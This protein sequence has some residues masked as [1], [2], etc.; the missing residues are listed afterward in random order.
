MALSAGRYV[1][2]TSACFKRVPT[3]RTVQTVRGATNAAIPNQVIEDD[4]TCRLTQ[5]KQTRG[6]VQVDGETRD[7]RHTFAG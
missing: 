7:L 5:A 1:R 4:A 3:C 6:S 2:A